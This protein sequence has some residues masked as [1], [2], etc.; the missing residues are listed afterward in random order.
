MPPPPPDSLRCPCG[1]GASRRDFLRTLLAGAAGA[2]ALGPRVLAQS[3]RPRG[4]RVGWGRLVTPSRF[5]NVHQNQ[6]AVLADFIRGHTTLN[7]DPTCYPVE[8]GNL[9]QL[10]AFPL[11]FTNNI[12]PVRSETALANLR[13]YLKRG[14]F[15]YIDGCV[16]NAVT[17]SFETFYQRHVDFFARLIP[18]AELRMLPE[19]HPIWRAY[20]PVEE[21]SIRNGGGPRGHWGAIAEALYGVFDGDRMISLVSLDH[22][23][24]GWPN[25]PDKVPNLMKEIAN[26]YVYAMT[27]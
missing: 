9:E 16:N 8:P 3:D 4:G 10:G 22:L 24:C 6:D 27:R 18:G 11:L 26:I 2:I 25:F 20:F 19:N 21:A 7:I 5:W 12:T 13:E 17:P 14:G 23:Q 1:C 15:F